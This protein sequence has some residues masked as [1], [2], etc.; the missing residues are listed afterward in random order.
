M[1]GIGPQI[2]PEIA[3]KLGIQIGSR[4][5]D[6][7]QDCSTKHVEIGPTMPS[8]NAT[9]PSNEDEESS[10]EEGVGPSLELAG[11]SNEQAHQ[12]TLTKLDAQMESD[13]IKPKQ[14]T[15]EEWMLVPPSAKSGKAAQD[16]AMF[17]ESWTQTP[18]EKRKRTEQKTK[19]PQPKTS[20][21]TQKKRKEDEEKA[22]WVNEY[23]QTQRPKTLMEMHQESKKQKS[24]D[25]KTSK[26]DEWSRRRFDRDRDLR[27]TTVSSRR[28]QNA[29]Q[30]ALE[31]LSD[32]Y[33]PGKKRSFL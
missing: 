33:V 9:N 6:E 20:P 16:T 8:N 17:D 28:Q 32:K 12:Q 15:R 22:H 30:D 11:C 13:Q 31:S 4:S 1:S 18:H 25:K 26:Q 24:K 14:A 3:A 27:A 19:G 21:S 7:P 23:N 5:N 29:V 10:D 2:P